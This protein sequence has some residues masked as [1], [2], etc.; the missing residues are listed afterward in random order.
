LPIHRAW[1]R[2]GIVVVTF[3]T[4]FVSLELVRMIPGYIAF[5]R[6]L[7]EVYWWVENAIRPLLPVGVGMRVL[8][9]PRPRA[10][11]GAIGLDR[12][13]IPALVLASILTLPL[14]L[15]PALLGVAPNPRMGLVDE[16]FGAGI[17]PLAEEINFRGFAFGQ[18]YTQSGLGFWPAGVF[19][20]V[21]FGIAHMANAAAA[22]LD[23][24]GQWANAGIVGSSA[25][26]LAWVYH[27]WDRNLWLV[28]FL[29]GLGN[30]AAAMYMTGEVA[31]GDSV[32]TTL[33]AV[34]LVVAVCV[35]LMKDRWSWSAR[36]QGEFQGSPVMAPTD[37]VRAG[38]TEEDSGR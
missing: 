25:L 30:L 24:A 13:V 37:A 5:F 34:T 33:L 9:G 35:T 19:T 20:S 22:G 26:G 28:F 10:W 6:D 14:T 16:V 17:W 2:T 21:L 31:A 8:Y 27:R 29:H 1:K 11:A 4:S 18:I 15:G 23:L 32:F 3:L 38:T 12:P 36:V 7:P